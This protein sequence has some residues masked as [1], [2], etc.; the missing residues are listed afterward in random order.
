MLR[1]FFSQILNAEVFRSLQEIHGNNYQSFMMKKLIPVMGNVRDAN[2]GI[3]ATVA[4]D[5]S[6]EVDV[7][8]NSAANTTFDE[9]FWQKIY[10]IILETVIICIFFSMN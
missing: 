7:I 1:F 8:V 2:M 3:E 5:I 6:M 10:S 4:E 9:R